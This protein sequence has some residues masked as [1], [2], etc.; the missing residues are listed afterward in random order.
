MTGSDVGGGEESSSR[1][2]EEEEGGG[3]RLPAS[4]DGLQS[5][6]S[7]HGQATV[8]SNKLSASSETTISLQ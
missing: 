4:P 8:Q 1:E 3:G 5:H 2:E 6:Q 7:G